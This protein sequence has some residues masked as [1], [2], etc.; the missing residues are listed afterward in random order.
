MV[1]SQFVQL[2]TI[3][4]EQVEDFFEVILWT[5]ICHAK[6]LEDNPFDWGMLKNCKK[7]QFFLAIYS[8]G[9]HKHWPTQ[10]K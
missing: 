10:G 3:S 7:G 2:E 4:P 8:G 6:P 5:I 1:S 9:G